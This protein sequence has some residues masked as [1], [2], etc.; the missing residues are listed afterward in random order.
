MYI[1]EL[2]YK[3]RFN[4]EIRYCGFLIANKLSFND[5]VECKQ[6]LTTYHELLIHYSF[7]L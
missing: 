6:S 2:F 5:C 7:A 1:G 3:L 4:E